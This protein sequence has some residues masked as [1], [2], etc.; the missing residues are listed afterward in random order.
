MI[1]NKEAKLLK[2]LILFPDLFPIAED[3]LEEND[4][5]NPAFQQIYVESRG[6]FLNYGKFDLE[7]LQDKLPNSQALD[8][9]L[10]NVSGTYNESNIRE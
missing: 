1:R 9:I 6:I 8:D 5:T 10:A 2:T 7:L 4:F 3:L